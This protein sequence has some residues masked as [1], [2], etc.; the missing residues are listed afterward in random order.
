MFSIYVTLMGSLQLR[1]RD[2]KGCTQDQAVATKSIQD[3]DLGISHFLYWTAFLHTRFEASSCSHQLFENWENIRGC[4]RT[5]QSEAAPH[6]GQGRWGG[7]GPN[8]VKREGH[9]DLRSYLVF[10]AQWPLPD[11]TETGKNSNNGRHHLLCVL[12]TLLIM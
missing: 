9:T 2:A 12:V 7:L 11:G 5:P 10:I 4:L 8:S 1:C 3:Q 6:F